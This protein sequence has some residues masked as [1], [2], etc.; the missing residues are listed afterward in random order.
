M[1]YRYVQYADY[2]I[3][4]LFYKIFKYDGEFITPWKFMQLRSLIATVLMVVPAN[5]MH[6]QQMGLVRLPLDI[7]FKKVIMGVF[8]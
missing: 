4:K 6:Y 8:L 1:L 2:P 7:K 3:N 5:L